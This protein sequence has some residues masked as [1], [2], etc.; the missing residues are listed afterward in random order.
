MEN[1]SEVMDLSRISED[2]RIFTTVSYML[3]WWSSVIV[4]QGFAL[5]QGMLPPIGSMNIFQAIT[6]MI[7]ASLI[8]ASF[9]SLNGK[10]GMKYGIPFAIHAR[11]AFGYKGSKIATLLRSVPAIFWFGIGSWIGA[12]AITEVMQTL[13]GIGD[14]MVVFIVFQ[15]LQVF[16]AAMGMKSIKWFESTMA[17][18]IVLIMTYMM[19]AITKN[20]STELTANWVA[21]GSW[22]MPFVGAIVMLVGAVFTSAINNSDLTRYLPNKNKSN[23]LGHLLGIP[24]SNSF[25]IILGIMAGAA[26]GEWDPVKALVKISP[27]TASA[28]ILLIFIALAQI[29]TNLTMNLLPAALTLMD[30]V[31]KISWKVSVVVIGALAVATCPW[32]IFTSSN[33]FMFINTYSAFLG[34]VLGVMLA[35]FYIIRKQELNVDELYSTNSKLYGLTGG[36][37]IAAI[38]SVVIG[39]IIGIM[40]TQLSWMVSAPTGFVLYAVLNTVLYKKHEEIATSLLEKN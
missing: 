25:L 13:F 11:S 14:V 6:A 5:G 31:K 22:G 28:I 21:K 4:I 20:F 23:W 27:N 1:K 7:V 34:P 10:A 30:F 12:S 24:I 17:I 40:F 33:F 16:L 36:W 18:V 19:I 15:A 38:I 35:D 37:N 2:K 29:T 8:L 26:V 3:M 32:V 9:F 39:G